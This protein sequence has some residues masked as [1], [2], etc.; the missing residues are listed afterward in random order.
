[1]IYKTNHGIK[2]DL[3]L[4]FESA[5]NITTSYFSQQKFQIESFKGPMEE[6]IFS[7]FFIYYKKEE[8]SANL[9]GY[10]T[11]CNLESKK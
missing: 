4:E 2:I 11:T 7:I 10:I 9:T 3:N 8:C 5:T 1:M 6:Q